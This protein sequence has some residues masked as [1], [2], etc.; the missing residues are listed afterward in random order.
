MHV[1]FQLSGREM[2]SFNPELAAGDNMEDGD[3]AFNSYQMNEEEEAG[4]FQV[5]FNKMFHVYLGIV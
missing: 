3:E 5:S 4:D 2:F 1:M